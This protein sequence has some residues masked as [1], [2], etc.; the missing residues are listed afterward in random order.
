MCWYD[1]S[2]QLFCVRE[3]A[4]LLFSFFLIFDW[5]RSSCCFLRFVYIFCR[6][7]WCV[8]SDTGAFSRLQR[9]ISWGQSTVCVFLFS[10]FFFF[11]CFAL[12]LL[13]CCCCRF[14]DSKVKRKEERGPMGKR[15]VGSPGSSRTP[16]PFCRDLSPWTK[17]RGRRVFH[18]LFSFSSSS[19]HSPTLFS[20]LLVVVDSLQMEMSLSPPTSSS[21]SSIHGMR[22]NAKGL[23]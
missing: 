18:H 12:A 21:S 10:F 7:E 5:W 3:V 16:S 19:F 8:V 20:L 22:A 2:T 11:F 15:G 14:C 13:C 6:G 17:N 9:W 1:V 23:Q 4:I